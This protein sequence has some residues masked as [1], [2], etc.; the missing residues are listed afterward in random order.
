MHRGNRSLNELNIIGIV[1]ES[2]IEVYGRMTKKIQT[3][4]N[5][6][7]SYTT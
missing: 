4:V 1:G 3:G 5:F 7:S 2:E 6:S